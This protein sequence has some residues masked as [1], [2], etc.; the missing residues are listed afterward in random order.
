[1]TLKGILNAL[2]RAK[3]AKDTLPLTWGRVS[4]FKGKL[5]MENDVIVKKFEQDIIDLEQ[6]KVA[7]LDMLWAYI[8][9]TYGNAE[10]TKYLQAGIVRQYGISSD[11]E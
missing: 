6:M 5:T 11:E 10:L 8:E 2:L 4:L 3:N 9:K 1:M 7:T